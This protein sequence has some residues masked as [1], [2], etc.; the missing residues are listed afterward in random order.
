MIEGKKEFLQV[1]YDFLIEKVPE[2]QLWSLQEFTSAMLLVG[3][4]TFCV[5][6]N[7]TIT[8]V[9][10]PLSDMLNHKRPFDAMWA[11]DNEFQG[12]R[13]TAANDIKKDDEIFD[14][15]G[16]KTSYDFLLHYGFIYEDEF[17]INPMDNLEIYFDLDP[18]DPNL[19]MKLKEFF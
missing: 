7:G 1:N 14:S 19:D 13:M 2:I 18:N 11:Y 3:S 5:E 8:N 16:Q 17:G 12:F 9:M 15:Y 4:R 6:I 10:V